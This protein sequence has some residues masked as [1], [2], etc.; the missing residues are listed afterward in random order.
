M[1]I[2]CRKRKY[3]LKEFC[4]YVAYTILLFSY[5]LF[6]EEAVAVQK[7]EANTRKNYSIDIVY[8]QQQILI[9]EI[10]AGRFHL[11]PGMYLPAPSCVR[12]VCRHE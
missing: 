11:P 7:C 8:A 12:T 5:Y 9:D 1:G 10:R 2:R 3:L 6:V 4:D